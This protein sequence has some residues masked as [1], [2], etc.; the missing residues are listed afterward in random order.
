VDL[1][2]PV[3][4]PRQLLAVRARLDAGHAE[5]APLAQALL[6]DTAAKRHITCG[7]LTIHADR[8]SPMVAKPVAFLLADLG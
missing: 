3:G 6:A 4:D 2:L 7:Q 8:G 5:N 1:L